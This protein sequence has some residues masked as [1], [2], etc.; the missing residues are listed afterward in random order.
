M[1]RSDLTLTFYS[2]GASRISN[3]TPSL[4]TT[5]QEPQLQVAEAQ[6][7]TGQDQGTPS[8]A[9][10]DTPL[11]TTEPE[12]GGCIAWDV[13]VPDPPSVAPKRGNPRWSRTKEPHKKTVWPKQRDMKA[14]PSDS[15]SGGGISFKSNSNGDPNY[16]VRKLMDWNGDWLPPPEEWSARKGHTNRHFGRA[17]EQWID[18]HPESCLEK[19]DTSLPAFSND[20][21]CKEVAPRYWVVSTIE[22]GSLG[23]FWKGMPMRQPSALSDISVRPPFW[24]RYEEEPSY[25]I[26]GLVVPDVRVDPSDLE[27]HRA[28]AD[29]LTC[30]TG[31]VES[32]MQQRL[33][34]QR[35][36]LAKQRRPIRE[37]IPTAPQLPDRRILPRSNIYFRPVGPK[38]LEGIAVSKCHSLQLQ[39]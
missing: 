9:R 31:R 22:R 18:G 39:F 24:E 36:A 19:M 30:A 3:Q 17:I 37:S 8:V 23:E 7:G 11:K 4:A 25:F 27:N 28:G 35:R 12:N 33:N 2:N 14:M 20:K 15:S 16:D 5:P 13:P 29:L 32:I 6:T 21:D 26:D 34:V 10:V 1:C 38:D